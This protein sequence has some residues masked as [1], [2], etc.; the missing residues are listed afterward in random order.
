MR[1]GRRG[2]ATAVGMVL[3]EQQCYS[4]RYASYSTG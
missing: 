1:G 2:I 3:D 4:Y